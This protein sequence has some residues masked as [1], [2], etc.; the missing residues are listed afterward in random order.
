M[1]LTSI[2]KQCCQTAVSSYCVLLLGGKKT[3]G[4]C[5]VRATNVD[6]DRSDYFM[7]LAQDDKQLQHSLHFKYLVCFILVLFK[8][9]VGVRLLYLPSNRLDDQEILVRFKD[10]AQTAVFKDPVRTAL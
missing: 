3:S 4:H 7:C 2:L 8:D 6:M 9:N 10:K 5:S 1:L